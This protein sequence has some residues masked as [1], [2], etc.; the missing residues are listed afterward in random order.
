MNNN[1]NFRNSILYLWN[2]P[3]FTTWGSYIS[4]L[5]NWVLLLPIALNK[6]PTQEIALWY[7]FR[8]I[9]DLRPI[10][11]MGFSPTFIRQIAYAFGGSEEFEN[12]IQNKSIAQNRTINWNLIEK[13]YFTMEV[14]YKRLAIIMLFILAIP[15]TLSALRLVLLIEKPTLGWVAWGLVI[16]TTVFNFRGNSFTSLLQGSNNIPLYRRWEALFAFVAIPSGALALLLGGGLL[17]LVITEQFWLILSVVRNRI[18][19]KQI[20]PFD[21]NQQAAKHFSSKIFKSVWPRSW[22]SGIGI[23]MSSGV[24]QFS[25]LIYA[26][27]GDIPTVAAYLLSL[28]FAQNIS[29]FSRV[30]FYSRLPQ[31]AILYASNQLDEL[32]KIAKREMK[33][34]HWIYSIGFITFGILAPWAFTVIGSNA[35][36]VPL[37]LWAVIGMGFFAERYGA[38]H[39]QLYTLTNQVVWH[40]ANGITGLITLGFAWVTIGTLGVYAFPIGYAVANIGFYA[41]YSAKLS[42]QTFRF[43][44]LEVEG[45]T[46]FLPLIIFVIFTAITL[47]RD[48]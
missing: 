43:R 8:I 40:I 42:Y 35:Q 46:L 31:M 11:D 38:M 23:L 1:L 33:A 9:T 19:T 14:T 24:M 44:F 18:L 45:K 22:R 17:S 15:C 3:T 41:W 36:F 16:F 2:S 30:P 5:L 32:V 27:V 34:S 12:P 37:T 10:I 25:G 26:Q 13:A 21:I 4:T 7:F 6:L 48:V 39:L 29:T 47:I 20:C 28:R